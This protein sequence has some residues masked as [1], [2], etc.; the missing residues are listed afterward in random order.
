MPTYDY[1]CKKCNESFSLIQSIKDHEEKKVECPK[2]KGKDVEQQVTH[3]MTKT[4][5]KS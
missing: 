3:F 1:F 4:S 2:C 5:R